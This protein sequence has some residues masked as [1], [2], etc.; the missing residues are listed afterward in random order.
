M[1]T[2]QPAIAGAPPIADH[3]CAG[4][5]AHFRAVQEGLQSIGLPFTVNPRLV[6]GLDY[7]NNGPYAGLSLSF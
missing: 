6:R 1:K 5:A 7:Y 4:C 3:L 2:C